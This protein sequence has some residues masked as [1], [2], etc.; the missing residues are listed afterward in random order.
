[1]C[2][3]EL[4]EATNTQGGPGA[5]VW[6]GKAGNRATRSGEVKAILVL[7]MKSQG[8]AVSVIGGRGSGS[9]IMLEAR[10]PLGKESDCLQMT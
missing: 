6:V 7:T 9:C 2:T 8:E 10:L 3:P 1:M 5:W 4:G